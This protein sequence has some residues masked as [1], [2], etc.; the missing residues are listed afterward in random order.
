[1][2]ICSATG[3]DAFAWSRTRF[4]ALRGR[5]VTLYASKAD[6]ARRSRTS[7]RLRGT[8]RFPDEAQRWLG[9][10]SEAPTQP[11]WTGMASRPP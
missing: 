5:R 7:C 9:S 8:H 1:M 6:G 4:S 3:A 11:P 10:G 2:P